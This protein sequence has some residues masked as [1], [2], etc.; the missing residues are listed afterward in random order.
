MKQI[1]DNIYDY[2]SIS[3]IEE[4]LL[5]QP[6]VLRL[7]NILQNSTVYHTY[8]NNRATRFCHSL[9]AMHLAGRQFKSLINNSSKKFHRELYSGFFDENKLDVRMS[10]AR[11]CKYLIELSEESE[12]TM[13]NGGGFYSINGWSIE[14][15]KLQ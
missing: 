12:S 10:L 5:S 15:D 7:H 8:P 4:I 3:P 13:E 9:G 11:S 14:A 1:R 6:E 2:I